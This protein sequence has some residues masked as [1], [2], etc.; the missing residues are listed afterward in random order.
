MELLE[1]SLVLESILDARNVCLKPAVC[2]CRACLD[3][4]SKPPQNRVAQTLAKSISTSEPPGADQRP[5]TYVEFRLVLYFPLISL[6]LRNAGYDILKIDFRN[7]ESRLDMRPV[8][9]SVY[10]IL[11]TRGI[12]VFGVYYEDSIKTGSNMLV[13]VVKSTR[14][15]EFSDLSSS[16]DDEAEAA[17][18]TSSDELQVSRLV[19][20]DAK[21]MLFAFC[22]ESNPI[23]IKNVEFRI[24]ARFS[25]AEIFYEKTAITELM[26][27]FKTD[28]IDFGEVKKI[29]E[30][31]TKAG[32]IYAVES[33]KQ[34]HLSAELSSPYF[35][36][37]AKGTCT[38]EGSSI[39]LFLGK[40]TLFLI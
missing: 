8:A 15:S 35:I 38:K 3:A 32:V 18:T 26:R 25:Q 40:K 34:F 14:L 9:N 36:I 27:F 29:R 2:S 6:R 13:P 22:F 16:N 37:P 30:V 23:E 17:T 33:H 24:R 20:E 11:N 31:W 19:S 5:L 12:D 28:L 1:E 39:V 21:G 7:I 10:F 4:K